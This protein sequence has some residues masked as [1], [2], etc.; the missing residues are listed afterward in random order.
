[1][2][3]HQIQKIRNSLEY[4]NNKNTKLVSPFIVFMKPK[5]TL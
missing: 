2:G 5:R 1:M 4:R 3:K